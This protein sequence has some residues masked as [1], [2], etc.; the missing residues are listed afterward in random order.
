MGCPFRRDAAGGGGDDVAVRAMDRAHDG[1]TA[2][3]QHH[4]R[5]YSRLV[6][7]AGLFQICRFADCLVDAT[8]RSTRFWAGF[9]SGGS[10]GA[11]RH[12]I[13]HLPCDFL[14]GRCP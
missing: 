9:E 1:T 13:F 12:F 4:Q 6:G 8:G 14:S 3:R 11:G 7:R 5:G 10:G 2:A